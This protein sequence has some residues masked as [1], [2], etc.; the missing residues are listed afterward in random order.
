M[1]VL[2]LCSV[3]HGLNMEQIVFVCRQLSLGAR[4]FER[5]PDRGQR[6][7]V[8]FMCERGAKTLDRL[9]H[10]LPTQLKRLMMYRHDVFRAG[11]RQIGK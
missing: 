4:N 2:A 6:D 10:W 8:R 11:S 1:T 7:P 9:E 3:T 5:F